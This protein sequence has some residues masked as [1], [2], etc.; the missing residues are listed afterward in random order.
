MSL[1]NKKI[2][3]IICVDDEKIVLDVLNT[4]LRDY[5]KEAYNYEMAESGQEALQIIEELN[6]QGSPVL[7]VIA[8]QIMPGLKGD[9]LLSQ[10]HEKYPKMIKIL[11]TGQAS[12]ESAINSINKASIYKYITKP[13]DKQAFLSAIDAGLKEFDA[14]ELNEKKLELFQYKAEEYREFLFKTTAIDQIFKLLTEEK[15]DELLKQNKKILVYK[16]FPADM[17]STTLIYSILAKTKPSALLEIRHPKEDYH[18]SF[19]GMDP[20][21][22][23]HVKEGKISFKKGEEEQT[24]QGDPLKTLWE[25]S[26]KDLYVGGE[27]FPTFF[28]GLIG[29]MAYDAIRLFEDLPS[30]HPDK[31]KYPDL[32]FHAYRV[33]V[34]LDHKSQIMTIG[35]VVPPQKEAYPRA[36][37]E[38]EEIHKLLFSDPIPQIKQK[39]AANV[40]VEVEIDDL[41]FASLVLEAKEFIKSGVIN[42]AI[43][44]RNFKRPF[45]GSPIMLYR[46]SRMLNPSPY[47]FLFEYPDFAIVG[48]SPGKLITVKGRELEIEAL[49]GTFPRLNY[50]EDQKIEELLRNNPKE[51]AEHAM[52]LE[53]VKQELSK[54]S[55]Q[56]S[57]QAKRVKVLEYFSHVIHIV[58]YV[59]GILSSEK[60]PLDA[61]KGVFP[62]GTLSGI[63]KVKAMEIID[64]IEPSRRG[65]YSGVIVALDAQGNLES[66]LL[67]RTAI[68]KNGEAFVRAGA[69]IVID[70]D[71]MKEA[72]ESLNKAKAMLESLSIS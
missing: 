44:S 70:S 13:W 25:I 24:L 57:V 5:F 71:P 30:R 26:Q 67:N 41:K 21:L 59:T 53:A 14:R 38:I 36:L 64:R 3:T 55:V 61:L 15:F 12:L 49:A 20:Y 33:M 28:G 68:L 63:P 43:I 10:L 47:H 23:Y 16:Q 35:L 42:K 45:T 72:E 58:S 34:C 2:P 31:N 40:P 32:L 56:E 7:M 11:L 37:N 18:Y 54:I 17:I 9:E 8:D 48:A 22:T 65:I 27:I 50:A 66:I 69:G 62:A 51:N 39:Y 6:S 46:N 29:F 52:L 19:I 60:T 4:Q 1:L